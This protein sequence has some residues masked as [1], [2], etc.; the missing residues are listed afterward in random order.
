[1][2][3]QVRGFGVVV[4]SFGDFFSVNSS[5]PNAFPKNLLFSEYVLEGRDKNTKR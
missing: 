4:S 1:M 3:P 5:D 2:C